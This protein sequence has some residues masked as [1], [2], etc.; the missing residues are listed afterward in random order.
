M[1]MPPR[2]INTRGRKEA[3]KK[4]ADFHFDY[5]GRIVNPYKYNLYKITQAIQTQQ[6]TALIYLPET[7]RMHSVKLS[8][9]AAGVIA[10]VFTRED[11]PKAQWPYNCMDI[12]YVVHDGGPGRLDPDDVWYYTFRSHRSSYD[13]IANVHFDQPPRLDNFQFHGDFVTHVRRPNTRCR[14]SSGDWFKPMEHCLY[15]SNPYG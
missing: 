12:Y 9:G 11:M 15:V 1:G 4:A 10:G 5:E 3:E 14:L 7:T 13:V 2:K 6:D 8:K